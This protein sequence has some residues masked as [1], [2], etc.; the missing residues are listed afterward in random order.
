MKIGLQV[1]LGLFSVIP[2]AFAGLGLA[3]G[4]AGADPAATVSAAVDNQYRYMSGV[5]VLVSFLLWYAIPK[6]ETH[7]RL[8]CF[9]CAALVIGGAGRLVSHLTVGPGT[10]E[11]WAGMFIELG[12][13]VLL[14]WL[15]FVVR[16]PKAA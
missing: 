16:K 9:I 5:Y 2:L 13:P 4:M 7:F 1:V 10:P 8:M 15:W 11:Q 12:S 6:I 3:S 14:L